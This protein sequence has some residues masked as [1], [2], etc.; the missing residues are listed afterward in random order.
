[1]RHPGL[2]VDASPLIAL[3]KI[4][5][6]D[7]LGVLQCT[8]YITDAVWNEVAGDMVWPGAREVAEAVRWGHIKRVHEGSPDAYAELGAGESAT[9]SALQPGDMLL[10]DDRRALKR[11]PRDPHSAGSI[12]ASFTT[13]T[14][15][16]Y[17]KRVGALPALRPVLDELIAAGFGIASDVYADALQLAGEAGG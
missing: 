4:G 6:L 3:A 15:L 16:L 7:L 1:M 10:M 17:A 11:V 13:V 12:A 9:I 8:V 14:L 2:V 5:R